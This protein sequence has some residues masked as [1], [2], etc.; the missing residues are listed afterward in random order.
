MTYSLEIRAVEHNKTYGSIKGANICLKYYAYI[1]QQYIS[2][3]ETDIK[4]YFEAINCKL[5]YDNHKELV[6]LEP[7]KMNKLVKQQYANLSN[8]YVGHIKDL[9]KKIAKP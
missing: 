3:A 2:K 5:E 7:Q 8:L 9:I 6:I 4:E 1:D